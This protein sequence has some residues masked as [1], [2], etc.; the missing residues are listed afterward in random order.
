MTAPALQL[1]VHQTTHE[2][3][4]IL[5][6]DLRPPDGGALAPFT[7]G[8]HIDL[9]LPNGLVRS[10]SLVNSQDETH[11]YVIAVNHDGNSRGG[12]RFLHQE[13]RTGAI[14]SGTAPRNNF[15][16]DESA[17]SSL[18]V[19]GGIGITP[20]LCMVQRLTELQRQWTLYYSARTRGNAAF[21]R[22]LQLLEAS[23]AGTVHLVFDQGVPANMLNLDDV[24]A[25]ATR[26]AHLYCCGPLAML[27]AFE[28]SASRLP[29][30]QVHLEYFAAKAPPSAEGGFVVELARSN[31]LVPVPKG[32]TILDALIDAGVQVQYSC[33]QG[34]CS[35]CETRVL[36]GIPDHKDLVLTREEQAANNVMMI[37]CSGSR[38]EKLVLDL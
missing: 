6:F 4:G 9:H 12:S 10:Y 20:I 31:R 28:K 19:A 33:A 30:Q 36:S 34:V 2:A 25:S 26:G 14:L 27:A 37:C 17:D 7:A 22:K 23:G 3:S 15:R 16:L 29:Q 8:A 5:S 35:T 1:R 32:K 38:S 13:L 24:V 11:R 21:L 18:F